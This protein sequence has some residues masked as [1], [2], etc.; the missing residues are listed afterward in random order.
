MLK[1]LGS[2]MAAY[3]FV[4]GIFFV[5]L[6]TSGA[7]GSTAGRGGSPEANAEVKSPCL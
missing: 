4:W 7:A 3:L 2:V 5:Y 6:I 1:N